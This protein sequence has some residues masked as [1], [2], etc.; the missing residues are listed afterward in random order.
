MAIKKYSIAWFIN[1]F[2][3]IPAKEW[4]VNEMG[5]EKGQCCALGHAQ[6]VGANR[7]L[8]DLLGTGVTSSIN[9]NECVSFI[10]PALKPALKLKTPK[11]R[12]LKALRILQNKS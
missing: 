7:A 3:K 6:K 2:E 11:G 12:I 5:N 1:Y 10:N 9:D 4:C 8:M